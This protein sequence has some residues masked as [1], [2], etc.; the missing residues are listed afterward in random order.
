[1]KKL[2]IKLYFE[3]EMNLEIKRIRTCSGG[4]VLDW[5]G[6][7]VMQFQLRWASRQALKSSPGVYLGV[8]VSVCVSTCI[9]VGQKYTY[10]S[11]AIH[12][13]L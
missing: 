7:N 11:F 8:G 12:I 3:V 13:I 6:L 2:L 9:C 5:I 10:L 4:K 1:M